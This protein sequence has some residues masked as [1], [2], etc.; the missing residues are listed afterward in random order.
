MLLSVIIP[1]YN[2]EKF[3]KR[4]LDSLILPNCPLFEIICI[5]DGSKDNSGKICD[6]YARKYNNIHVFH[7]Q[8]GGVASAR[9]MGLQYATGDYIA[10]LDADDY[11]EP[12]W[13][14]SISPILE[15][16]NPD[17]LLFDYYLVDGNNRYRQSLEWEHNISNQK[18]IFE[19]TC[20]NR[21]KSYLWMHIIKRS[22][23]EE[24]RFST[25]AIVLEDYQML[26]NIAENFQTIIY[27]NKCLYNYVTINNSLSRDV[28]IRKSRISRNI[29][30]QR[31]S[32]FKKK[33]YLVSKVS[34]W[35]MTIW[36]YNLLKSSEESK[37]IRGELQKDYLKILRNRYMPI[38]LKVAAS[39]CCL[40][41]KQTYDFIHALL[42]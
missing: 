12:Q 27:I 19:L 29:A 41:N 14:S 39:L 24:Q 38:K 42:K 34:Y 22:I 26:T 15:N 36:L 9:N 11:I 3:I 16:K 2:A 40:F 20:D 35:K 1:V 33:G 8:N 13:F 10:W 28:D 5:D 25:D 7:K 32:F 31:Y 4:A 18:Y 21:L 37:E 6:A 17:C 30:R 23:L